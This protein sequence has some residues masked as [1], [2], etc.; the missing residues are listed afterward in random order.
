[1]TVIGT[2]TY[3]PALYHGVVDVPRASGGRGEP[4]ST[5]HLPDDLMFGV[6]LKRFVSETP[7]LVHHTTK[8]PH[9]TSCGVLLVVKSLFKVITRYNYAI[10]RSR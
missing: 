6:S 8:A 7:Y 3:V 1:M 5:V 4:E 9:I 2:I 10:H